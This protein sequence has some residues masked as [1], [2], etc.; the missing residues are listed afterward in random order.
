[1][2]Y[3]RFVESEPS[4]SG[5][6]RR[7]AVW[8]VAESVTLGV[9]SWFAPWR[10]YIFSPHPHTVY[11]RRCLRD[12]AD[13]CEQQTHEHRAARKAAKAKAVPA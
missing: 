11:E 5:K 12:L 13:F 3:L 9:V 8:S 10:C 4:P 1:V 7:W 6:T 2:S